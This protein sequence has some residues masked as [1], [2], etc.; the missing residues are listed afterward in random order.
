MK[1]RFSAPLPSSLPAAVNDYADRCAKLGTPP[2]V[3]ELAVTLQTS[4]WC[5]CRAWASCSTLPLSDYLRRRQ[6]AIAARLLEETDN[7]IAIIAARTGY[8]SAR[9]FHRVFRKMLGT[10]PDEFRESK[11]PKIP[12]ILC[13]TTSV[14]PLASIRI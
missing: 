2:R 11:R 6:I 12:R 3:K 5:L 8:A 14:P 7:P 9:Q 4:R 13:Q 1:R 10:T